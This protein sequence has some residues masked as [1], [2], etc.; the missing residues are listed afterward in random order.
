MM[1]E[2]NIHSEEPPK[3]RPLTVVY[4]P[5]E[6]RVKQSRDSVLDY[7][8]MPSMKPM[9]TFGSSHQ[10]SKLNDNDDCSSRLLGGDSDLQVTENLTLNHDS[11]A[12]GESA[13]LRV[14]NDTNGVNPWPGGARPK[15][16]SPYLAGGRPRT[17]G[18]RKRYSDSSEDDEYRGR[19]NNSREN[20]NKSGKILLTEL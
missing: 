14:H 6:I 4:E 12:I 9:T 3:N 1:F 7:D 19:R 18:V 8:N 13:T 10:K 20:P 16:S 2:G 5:E 17:P 11:K 15:I